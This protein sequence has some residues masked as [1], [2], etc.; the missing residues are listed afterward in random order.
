MCGGVAAMLADAVPD[1]YLILESWISSTRYGGLH[2]RRNYFLTTCPE[3][4]VASLIAV[5]PLLR[6]DKHHV[7]QFRV[8]AL[9]STGPQDRAWVLRHWRYARHLTSRRSMQTMTCHV[10]WNSMPSNCANRMQHVHETE[11]NFISHHE[12]TL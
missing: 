4:H 6:A 5:H 12:W 2:A 8:P 1:Q 9:P 3:H 10:C 11:G 7:R